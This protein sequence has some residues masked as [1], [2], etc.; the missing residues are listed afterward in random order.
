[1][2]TN[3]TSPRLCIVVPCFNEEDV[4]QSTNRALLDL[5]ISLSERN[6]ISETSQ[7]LYVDDGS[8]D[9]T[10]SLID[11]FAHA[12][13][14]AQGIKLS[15]NVG[16][17]RA[18]LAGLLSAPGDVILS[19]DADL[20]DDLTAIEDMLRTYRLDGAEVV[21]GVRSSRTTDTAFKRYTAA[22]FYR[23]MRLLGADVVEN[24]ADFRLMSRRAVDALRD[25]RE[26]NLFL[27]GLV[28]LIGFRSAIVH[29][30][31]KERL[32]GQSKYPLKKMLSFALD[33]VTS[34]S[35]FPLRLITYIGA[36]VF[37]LSLLLSAWTLYVALFTSQAVPGWA[38]TVLPIYF[39]GG[40]QILS[41]GV[42]GE[43]AGK[44]YTE[45]KA[46]PRYFVETKVP[47]NSP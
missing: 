13:S 34:L 10:W 39:I 16:H 20:Q 45:V 28:P 11:R 22:A 32:A 25:F 26:V 9:A 35:A 18:L 38:S 1:M 46:R 29:Y 7:V 12:D 3:Q 4:L 19:I 21:Y 44:I 47:S 40:V 37:L 15:R 36:F 24:H 27:R 17:Q 43:Y 8:L 14:H 33:G 23:L 5:L 6:L 2:S 31:R 42:L 41:I 30:S